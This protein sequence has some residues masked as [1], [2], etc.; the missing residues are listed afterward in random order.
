MNEKKRTKSYYERYH[1]EK[2]LQLSYID[3]E[4]NKKL[5]KPNSFSSIM[6]KYNN[7]YSANKR[8]NKSEIEFNMKKGIE[9]NMSLNPGAKKVNIGKQQENLQDAKAN[10]KRS[11]SATKIQ[12]VEEPKPSK[13]TFESMFRTRKGVQIMNPNKVNQDRVLIEENMQIK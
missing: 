8:Y 12:V 3:K 1:T 5:L 6:K 9:N 10:K 2:K 13:I 11:K 4:R 7:S